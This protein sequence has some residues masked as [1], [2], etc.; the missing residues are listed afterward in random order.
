MNTLLQ[1]YHYFD[2]D[3]T[4]SCGMSEYMQKV[5]SNM[6]VWEND[7]SSVFLLLVTE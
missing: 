1:H 2:N 5:A 3:G 4:I 6:F 7:I